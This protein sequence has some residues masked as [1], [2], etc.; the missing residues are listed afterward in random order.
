MLSPPLLVNSIVTWNLSFFDF[1]FFCVFPFAYREWQIS[2]TDP[3]LG[4][5]A[6]DFVA[7]TRSAAQL[8]AT[9]ATYPTE[10]IPT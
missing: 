5:Y 6:P 8:F 1:G 2:L 10:T 4:F 7:R 3:L 9:F